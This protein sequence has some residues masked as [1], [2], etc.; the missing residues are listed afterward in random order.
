MKIVNIDGEVL[1]IFWTI[2][3]IPMKFSGKMWLMIIY[4]VTKNQG[5]ILSLENTF[6]KKLQEGLSWPL[7]SHLRLKSIFVRL[8]WS[9]SWCKNIV[10]DGWVVLLRLRFV[11]DEN[12]FSFEFSR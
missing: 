10:D 11:L 8:I 9:D 7:P 12:K 4:K 6:L 1:H 5:F 3:E 2:W